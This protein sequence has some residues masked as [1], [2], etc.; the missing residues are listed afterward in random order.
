MRIVGGRS[1]R[2]FRGAGSEGEE[3]GETGP[4]GFCRQRPHLITSGMIFSISSSFSTTSST[5]AKMR[6][7]SICVSLRLMLSDERCGVWA[8]GVVLRVLTAT[9]L[10]QLLCGDGRHLAA[11]WY[12]R[13][14]GLVVVLA[15]VGVGR[16]TSLVAVSSESAS[17]S[18]P[19]SALQPVEAH[20]QPSLFQL[21]VRTAVS[22]SSSIDCACGKKCQVHLQPVAMP[23]LW[24]G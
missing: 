12:Y 20:T 5:T 11:V 6:W 1:S 3:T 17:S 24:R 14:Y 8:P 7:A 19:S 18:L 2:L 22:S 9:P 10:Q 16:W 23:K 13:G 21:G 4:L 15:F